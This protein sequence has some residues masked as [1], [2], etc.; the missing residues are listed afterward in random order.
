MPNVDLFGGD[1]KKPP[2]DIRG[3]RYTIFG[4]TGKSPRRERAAGEMLNGG[5]ALDFT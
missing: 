1:K 2:S 3:G 5:V 4:T